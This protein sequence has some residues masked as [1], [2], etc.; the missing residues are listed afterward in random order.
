MKS[1]IDV[2]PVAFRAGGWSIEPFSKYSEV[3][4]EN[5]VLIDSTIY[6]GGFDYSSNQYYD[7]R[8]CPKKSFWNFDD[9]PT[10]ETDGYF[11][12]IPISSMKFGF[13]TSMLLSI[14]LRFMNKKMV[15]AFGDGSGIKNEIETNIVSKII[16]K[17]KSKYL[18]VSLDGIASC[19]LSKTLSK[20]LNSCGE[21]DFFVAIGHPKAQTTHS[22]QE[23]D[24]FI[25]KA[26]KMNKFIVYSFIKRV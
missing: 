12:E 23:L 4:R 22:L 17:F 18:G 2:K 24:R 15:K 11:T 16:N 6:F 26:K 21:Q 7:F 25:K 13:V 1:E 3:L 10:I 19:L 5:G 20:Q 14:K 9:A 8:N